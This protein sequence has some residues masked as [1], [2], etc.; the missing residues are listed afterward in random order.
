MS[1]LALTIWAVTLVVVAVVI[2]PL[3][4]SLLKRALT[5][6]QNIERYMADMLEAGKGIAGNTAAIPALDTTLATA[7]AM[8]PVAQDIATTAAAA[9]AFVT[10]GAAA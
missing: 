3:A 8:A 6:A 4:L 5:A 9:E 7:A 10:K 1:G 2:V